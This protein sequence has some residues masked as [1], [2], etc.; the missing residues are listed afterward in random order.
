LSFWISV[1]LFRFSSSILIFHILF[2][3]NVL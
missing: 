3:L 2:S 1:I